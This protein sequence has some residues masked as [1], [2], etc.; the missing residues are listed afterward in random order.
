MATSI[1]QR[2]SGPEGPVP[3]GAARLELEAYQLETGTFGLGEDATLVLHVDGVE[4]GV[5]Y[6]A[7]DALRGVDLSGVI[8]VELPKRRDE[9]PDTVRIPVE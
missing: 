2:A 7:L 9:T 4:R 8:E 3:A 6:S 1:G 5:G